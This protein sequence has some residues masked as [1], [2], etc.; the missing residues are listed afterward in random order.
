MNWFDFAPIHFG[1]VF[2]E[3]A[4]F[5][6]LLNYLF[7]E[8]RRQHRD[9]RSVRAD[10]FNYQFEVAHTQLLNEADKLHH[11]NLRLRSSGFTMNTLQGRDRPSAK[12]GLLA[13]TDVAAAWVFEKP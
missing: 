1:L 5:G 7:R 13:P 8:T 4:F 12:A 3:G 9:A 6:W 10:D 2:V 11:E